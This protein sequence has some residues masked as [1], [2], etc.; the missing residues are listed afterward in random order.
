M[1][2]ETETK[3]AS[4]YLHT[5]MVLRFEYIFLIQRLGGQIICATHDQSLL[6]TFTVCT[7]T[8]F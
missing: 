7:S 4:D 3:D 6:S 5:I 1:S 8:R 2:V